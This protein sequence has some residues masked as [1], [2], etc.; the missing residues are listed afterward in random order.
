MEKVLV[1]TSPGRTGNGM[2]SLGIRGGPQR[3][4]VCR[5]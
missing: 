5:C 4:M 2:F 1:F 3:E